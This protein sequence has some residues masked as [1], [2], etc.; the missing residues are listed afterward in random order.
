M[1][2]KYRPNIGYGTDERMFDRIVAVLAFVLILYGLWL[3][4]LNATVWWANWSHSNCV[5][6]S[7]N[8][9]GD[10]FQDCLCTEAAFRRAV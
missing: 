2:M 6:R 7:Q 3:L 9:L 8:Q 4:G 1:G 10:L 5:L